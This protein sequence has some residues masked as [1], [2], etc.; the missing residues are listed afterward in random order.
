MYWLARKTTSQNR[1]TESLIKAAENNSIKK[2]YIK[3]QIDIT[4]QN[5]KNRLYEER[6][7]TIYYIVS[8]CSNLA[9]KEYK[10]IHDWVRKVIHWEVCKRLSFD[11]TTK[12][13]MHK[14]ESVLKK[15]RDLQFLILIH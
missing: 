12:R 5:S 2:N 4:Q 6:D 15:K 14:P 3:V 8:E 11:H 9:Q 7:E 13:Y 1:K 10:H